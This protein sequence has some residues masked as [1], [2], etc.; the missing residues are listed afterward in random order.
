MN[1]KVVGSLI[2]VVVGLCLL[3]GSFYGMHRV[4]EAKGIGSDIEDFFTHNPSVWNP[5][6]EFF[7]GQAQEEISKYNL[8]ILIMFIAGIAFTVGGSVMFFRLKKGK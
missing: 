3:G 8:P 4:A 7:G 5:A 6:I 2:A 1:K